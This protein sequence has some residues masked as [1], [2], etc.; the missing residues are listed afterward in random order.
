MAAHDGHEVDCRGDEFLGCFTRAEMRSRL[1]SPRSGRWPPGARV[2][3]RMGLHTGEPALVGGA[4]VGIDVN[5]AARI[6]SA[7]HGG[8]ILISASTRDR[9]EPD[10]DV[11]DLGSYRL[12]AVDQPERIYE[13]LLAELEGGF[14]P[15][16][17]SSGVRRRGC[18]G[19]TGRRGRRWPRR[20]GRLGS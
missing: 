16:R 4:Y 3:V 7:A 11:R 15:I 13:V 14:P 12:A 9:L 5:R 6:C 17:A 18:G 8:Q 20:H 10:V 2:R 19:A 1:R